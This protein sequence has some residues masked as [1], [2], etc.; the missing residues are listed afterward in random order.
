[1]LVEEILEVLKKY[2][3]VTVTSDFYN[4]DLNKRQDRWCVMVSMH[5]TGKVVTSPHSTLYYAAENL[6][7]KMENH[8]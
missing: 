1:M 4:K 2:G 3:R 8:D 6:L 7:M 5:G